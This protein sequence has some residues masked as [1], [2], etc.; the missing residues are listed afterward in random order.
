MEIE[1]KRKRGRPKGSKNKF[2]LEK[3]KTKIINNTDN[4]DTDAVINE[5]DLIFFRP[6]INFKLPDESDIDNFKEFLKLEGI[7]IED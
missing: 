5:D 6:A 3:E 4:S 7:I 2:S 1:V